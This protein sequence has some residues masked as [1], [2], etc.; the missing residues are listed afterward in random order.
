MKGLAKILT[1]IQRAEP[2]LLASL[3]AH[4][5]RHTNNDNFSELMDNSKASEAAEEKQRSYVMGWK[6]GSGTAA[7]YTRR[8]TE[9]KAREASLKLQQGWQREKANDK[10]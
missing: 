7:T 1:K 4:V 3:T 5:L 2:S 10:H 8:H 9:K 6:E